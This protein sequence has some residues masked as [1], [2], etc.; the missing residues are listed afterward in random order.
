MSDKVIAF[1]MTL[2]VQQTLCSIGHKIHFAVILSIQRWRKYMREL[3]LNI[4]K[5]Y[6]TANIHMAQAQRGRAHQFAA[7][8]KI[9]Y[10]SVGYS[11]I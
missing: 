2:G 11:M 10:D 1:L 3:S 8:F 9:S 7:E 4:T 5:Y 6:R